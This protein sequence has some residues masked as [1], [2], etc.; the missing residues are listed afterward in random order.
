MTA[1]RKRIAEPEVLPGAWG[2]ASAL[3][4]GATVGVLVTGTA[5]GLALGGGTGAGV[6]L[7]AGAIAAI[8]SRLGPAPLG[9]LPISG[10]RR[11]RRDPARRS[12]PGRRGS[13]TRPVPAWSSAS[14][15]R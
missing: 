1:D 12:A 2:S 3:G 6:G 5:I 11:A 14:P 9:D 10:R 7:I 15:P 8:C 13:S 4:M